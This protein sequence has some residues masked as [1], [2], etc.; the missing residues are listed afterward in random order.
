[1]VS[2]TP[3]LP[4]MIKLQN[5]QSSFMPLKSGEQSVKLKKF[6]SVD[7]PEAQKMKLHKAVQGFEAIFIR[8]LL[9]N[10]RSTIPNGGM[11]GSGSVGEIYGD[12][13]DNALAET[14]SK[15]SV[16]GLSDVLYRQLVKDI[17]PE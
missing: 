4:N 10:M 1:M 17:V 2:L 13:M 8:Q 3:T 9:K 16:L 7:D 5:K 11:F 14:M 15:R 12:M 6:N